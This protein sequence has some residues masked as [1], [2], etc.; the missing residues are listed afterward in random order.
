MVIC[1]CIYIYIYRSITCIYICACIYIYIYTHKYG[2]LC[3]YIYT[4]KAGGSPEWNYMLLK[5]NLKMFILHR[6]F[7][8]FYGF[9]SIHRSIESVGCCADKLRVCP[10]R[11][12]IF[13]SS[14]D[15]DKN[16][17][18]IFPIGTMVSG[19]FYVLCSR[20]KCHNLLENHG[21]NDI[22]S[23]FQTSHPERFFERV[24]WR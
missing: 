18:F 14:F 8:V 7:T 11:N 21:R 12:T 23:F 17:C 1:V 13:Q 4:V 16:P 15:M 24:A 6:F 5:W 20:Q 9:V 19:F 3:M 2:D 10:R 22:R